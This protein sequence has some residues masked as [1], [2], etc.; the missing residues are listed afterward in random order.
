MGQNG[1]VVSLCSDGMATC[2]SS[3]FPLQVQLDPELHQHTAGPW[4][5]PCALC[6]YQVSF[7]PVFLSGLLRPGPV[8]RESQVN[9]TECGKWNK[10]PSCCYGYEEGSQTLQL[11]YLWKEGWNGVHMQIS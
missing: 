6:D 2:S 4:V 11:S 8:A 10:D 3:L 7:T 5:H 1:S 9:P